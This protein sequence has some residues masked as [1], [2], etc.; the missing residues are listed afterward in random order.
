MWHHKQSKFFYNWILQYIRDDKIPPPQILL[1]YSSDSWILGQMSVN[2]YVY[3]SV[4]FTCWI[5]SRRLGGLQRWILGK[6]FYEVV[7]PL[8]WS[9]WVI[10]MKDIIKFKCCIEFHYFAEF[11]NGTVNRWGAFPIH[12]YLHNGWR[13]KW[14]GMP[15]IFKRFLCPS[16]FHSFI[17]LLLRM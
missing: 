5:L 10:I 1:S 7:L 14:K 13:N 2:N 3:S 6:P 16:V 8:T 15:L 11:E 9:V 4:T 12:W 17:L